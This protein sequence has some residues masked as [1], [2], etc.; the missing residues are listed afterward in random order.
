MP[1]FPVQMLWKMEAIFVYLGFVMHQGKLQQNL[2]VISK[3]VAQVEKVTD[4]IRNF[5]VF[6][7]EPVGFVFARK[8]FAKRVFGVIG[9]LIVVHG[10]GGLLSLEVKSVPVED[11][12]AFA[13]L[14]FD[15]FGIIQATGGAVNFIEEA[16]QLLVIFRIRLAGIAGDVHIGDGGHGFFLSFH[17]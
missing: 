10:P 14:G 15:P 4:Q 2:V 12:T 13:L 1:A 5:V 11:L 16:L 17:G 8:V 3:A 9:S 7:R 6:G